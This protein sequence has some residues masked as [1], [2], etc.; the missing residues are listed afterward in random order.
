MKRTVALL[1]CLALIIPG[2]AVASANST[3][4][5]YGQS[6][7]HNVSAS[8]NP[9]TTASGSGGSSSTGSSGSASGSS[10]SGSMNGANCADTGPIAASTS[11][12]SLPFTGLDLAALAA[13]GAVLL[14]AGMVLRRYSAAN[15]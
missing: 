12:G 13:G 9:C 14:G 10:S 1:T 2:A 3:N 11:T 4:G 15:R 6:G 8:K 5:S 7:V